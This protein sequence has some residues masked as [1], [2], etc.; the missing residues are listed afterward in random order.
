MD[1]PLID[2][3][4][5][6]TIQT[7]PAV[8]TDTSYNG[9]NPDDVTVTVADDDVAGL[10]VSVSTLSVS[11]PDGTATFNIS[12]TSRPWSSVFFPMSVSNDE[13]SASPAYVWIAPDDWDS[14][15][16]VRVYAVDDDLDDGTQTC[17][18]QTGTDPQRRCKLRLV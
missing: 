4:Q 8:S 2:G 16:T 11:E 7:A 1:D 5:T 17:L 6:C 9:E 10:D 14:G 15:A 12:L 3:S 13:C 18:V